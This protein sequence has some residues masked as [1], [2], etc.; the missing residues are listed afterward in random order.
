M[1]RNISINVAKKLASVIGAPVIICGNSDYSITFTFDQEWE[2]LDL[3]TAR[4]VYKRD[5]ALKFVDVVFSGCTTSVPVLSNIDE[6]YVGVYSGELHTTTPA[7]IICKKSIL[8]GDSTQHEAPEPDVY[9]Q[10][11]EVFNNMETLPTVGEADAGR[12]LM[13]NEDGHWVVRLPDFMHDQNSGNLI[14]FFF[15][16]VDEWTAWTGDKENVLFVPTDELPITADYVKL[17]NKANE[18]TAF[19][20]M[21]GSGDENGAELYRATGGPTYNPLT[22]TLKAEN[23]EG[24]AANANYALEAKQAEGLKLDGANLAKNTSLGGF[25]TTIAGVYLCSCVSGNDATH[26]TTVA[27]HITNP[28][29]GLIYVPVQFYGEEEEGFPRCVVYGK[30]SGEEDT[31]GLKKYL[32]RS[33]GNFTLQAVYRLFC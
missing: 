29:E 30:Q 26:V 17:L 1:N 16:T 3:K 28:G 7:R 13:V 4:F 8:C 23:F 21:L 22:K 24:T 31:T 2:T 5:G 18:N 32:I 25:L 10:I 33:L 11:L 9:Q 19:D 14:R 20:L 27:L 6:V 12:A 15:G